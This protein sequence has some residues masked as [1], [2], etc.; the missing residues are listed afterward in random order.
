MA[1]VDVRAMTMPNETPTHLDAAERKYLLREGHFLGFGMGL[2]LS[3]WWWAAVVWGVVLTALWLRSIL[4]TTTSGLPE[5]HDG[6]CE[7]AC[8][9][10]HPDSIWPCEGEAGE[11]GLCWACSDWWEQD[12][13]NGSSAGGDAR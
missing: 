1:T 3:R 7:C 9:V 4:T 8:V 11:D 12:E 6:R 2:L 13:V 10:N 5:W